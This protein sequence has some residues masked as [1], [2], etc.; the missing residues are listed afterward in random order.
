MIAAFGAIILF[1]SLF[2]FFVTNNIESIN[3]EFAEYSHLQEQKFLAGKIQYS[4]ANVWQFFTDASLTQDEEVITGEAKL[5][6]DKSISL[7][8]DW[9]NNNSVQDE[10]VNKL[11]KLEQDLHGFYETGYKM[12]GAYGI[13]SAE[14]NQ[15]MEIFDVSAE[16]VL[17]NIDE[18][19]QRISSQSLEYYA[20]I[21][22]NG[23]STSF[24][25]IVTTFLL[26]ILIIPVAYLNVRYITQNIYKLESV[27]NRVAGGEDGVTLN[28][29]T[30]DE[31]GVL[32]DSFNAMSAKIQIQTE[33]L[34]NLPTPVMAMDTDFNITYINKAGAEI[35]GKTQ[36]EILGQK[37]YENMLTNDCNTKNCTCANAMKY[38][39]MHESETIARPNNNEISILYKGVATKNH[40]GEIVG[41]L[42]FITDITAAKEKQVY[43]DESTRKMLSEME[44]FAD[45][46]LLV[47][48]DPEHKNEI[49]DQLFQGFNNSAQ[50]IRKM[51]LQVSEVVMATVTAA[52]QISSS[53]EEMA[54]G[55]QEQNAQT[56]EVAA[57]IEEMAATVA[58]TSQNI[59]LTNKAAQESRDLAATGQNI[60]ESTIDG[61]K[62]IEIVVN[63][64]SE[65]ISQLG[66]SSEQIGQI[67]QVINDIADQTNLLALNAAIEAA[68]AGEHGRGFAVVADE[69]RKLAERTTVATKE[70]VGMVTKI[71]TDSENAVEAIAKGNSQVSDGM[72]KAMKAGSSMNEIVL[73]SDKV[74]GISSQ[75]AVAGEQQSATI[76]E[77][78]NSIQ[79]INNVA[80][81]ASQGVQQIA[82]ATNSLNQ[83][84]EELKSTIERF[85]LG[86]SGN[87]LQ[88]YS[89]GV[90]KN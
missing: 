18:L 81:E 19:E 17:T 32:A 48:L 25:T 59:V 64:A 54:A 26:I 35:T 82:G 71:Q 60:I 43:L 4:I 76:S 44:K 30:N 69:V 74:L 85:D 10:T 88:G 24:W 38:D 45:G 28:L 40:D 52:T 83:L 41:A 14:G 77:I 3:D 49:I 84:T 87:Q 80:Y 27:F 65:I 20:G 42:E 57:S 78:S 33:Y 56:N 53:T 34:N 50:N 63:E 12:F 51:L 8:N 62:S 6:F 90:L 29:Q 11:I 73:S 55:A 21:I 16:N 72:Q 1:T 5:F 46:N 31:F 58:E 61:M 36:H 37:C 22:A 67:V 2:S 75:V 86:V 79:S 89:R 68:R 23:E 13:S 39:E 70:I 9:K 66:D 7:I 47:N 15:A